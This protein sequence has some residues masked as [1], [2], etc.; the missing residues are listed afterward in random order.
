MSLVFFIIYHKKLLTKLLFVSVG[1]LFMIYFAVLNVFA[2]QKLKNTS[3]KRLNEQVLW[4]ER[5]R[6]IKA[7]QLKP[8][9]QQHRKMKALKER[10]VDNC[11]D[12]AHCRAH[13]RHCDGDDFAFKNDGMCGFHIKHFWSNFKGQWAADKHLERKSGQAKG[14]PYTV[15]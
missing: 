8:M 13:N 2:E 3:D 5:K 6:K 10:I 12:E 11:G 14:L 1:R 15:P 4:E 9:A 7:H